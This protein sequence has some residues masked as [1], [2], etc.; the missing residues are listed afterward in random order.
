[1]RPNAAIYALEI[2]LLSEAL[3]RSSLVGSSAAER[4]A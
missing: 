3:Q 4:V 1:M 2:C